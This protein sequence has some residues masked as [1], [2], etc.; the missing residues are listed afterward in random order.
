M[1]YLDYAAT[2]PIDKEVLDTYVKT[3]NNFFANSSSLHKLGQESNYMYQVAI[4]EIKK[5]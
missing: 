1:I 5:L 2:T 3:S 4:E